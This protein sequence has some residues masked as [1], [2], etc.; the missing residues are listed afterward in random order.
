MDICSKEATFLISV[1]TVRAW[2]LSQE[3][4]VK[5][6]VEEGCTNARLDKRKMVRYDDMGK[7][8]SALTG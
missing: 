2:H 7:F 1:A 4:F 6:F 3:L 5:K 8:D